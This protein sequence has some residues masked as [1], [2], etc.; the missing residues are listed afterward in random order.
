MSRGP[1][2]AIVLA[3]EKAIS[4]WRE[5]IGPTNT[6]KAR[7]THPDRSVYNTASSPSIAINLI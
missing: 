4:H 1:I 6:V 7:Q 5:L 3:R 2:I